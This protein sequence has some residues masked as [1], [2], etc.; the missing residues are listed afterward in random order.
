[1]HCS[2]F[3]LLPLLAL[4]SCTNARATDWQ[5]EMRFATLEA[6]MKSLDSQVSLSEQR[7]NIVNF[8]PDG[9][10]IVKIVFLGIKFGD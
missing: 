1:M 5:S 3:L 10:V 7:L 2:A 9:N 6:A 4:A 8:Q